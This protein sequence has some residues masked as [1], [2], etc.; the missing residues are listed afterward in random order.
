M[1]NVGN[2]IYMIL[3]DAAPELIVQCE[4]NDI[5][6]GGDQG[7]SIETRMKKGYIPFYQ[8]DEPLGHSF[9]EDELFLDF[10]ECFETFL[11]WIKEYNEEKEKYKLR[12]LNEQKTL[13]ESRYSSLKWLLETNLRNTPD[14]EK[15]DYIKLHN[16]YVKSLKNKKQGKDWF[17]IQDIKNLQKI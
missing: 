1:L 17:N 11:E 9:T 6:T 3:Y 8:L 12:D 15:E 5:W 10:R 7:E 14:E 16:E 2:K 13:D 4:V